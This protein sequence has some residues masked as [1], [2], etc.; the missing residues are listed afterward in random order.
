MRTMQPE[1]SSSYCFGVGL[2]WAGRGGT[3]STEGEG[4]ELKGSRGRRG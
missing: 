2:Q 4:K 1:V 3:K